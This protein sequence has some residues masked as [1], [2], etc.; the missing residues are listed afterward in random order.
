MKKIFFLLL[1]AVSILQ[2]WSNPIDEN[3]AQKVAVR[4]LIPSS[5]KYINA[6]AN[7]QK[8]E[9]QQSLKLIYKNSSKTMNNQHKNTE[10]EVVYF[11]VF[12]TENNSG[13]VIVAGDD[14]VTPVLG[15]SHTNGFSAD[16]MP[17]NLQWWL[18][19]YAK[20]IQFAIENDIEPT[21]EVK[22]QWVQYLGI[23][24]NGKEE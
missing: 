12:S 6:N 15:Y 8:N 16:N 17:P 2:L 14:R 4:V 5:A 19:E 23:N 7:Q 21:A 20:Q 10:N 11:Y 18:G 1:L 3:A 22:Q 13:F 24:D 9:E